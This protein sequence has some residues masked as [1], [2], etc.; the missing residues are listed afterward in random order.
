MDNKSLYT[1]NHT[2]KLIGDNK[3]ICFVITN[4]VHYSRCKQLLHTLKNH[5]T[6]DL[7]IVVAASALL[8]KYGEVTKELEKDGFVIHATINML[9]EGGSPIAMAKTTG[10]GLLEMSTVLE[11]LKPDIVVVRGDR[12]EVLSIAIAAAYLNIP[13]AHIEGG[14][15]T[16]TIDE[17]V[18]HAITKLAHL[19]FATNQLSKE[20][21][22]KMG[23]KQ[24]N[25]YD[26]GSLDVEYLTKL[27][28]SF[29]HNLWEVG[30][31]GLGTNFDLNQGYV[32]V[33]QHP[34][35]TEYGSGRQ[36]M[37]ET[38]KAI[39]E[40][41]VPTIWLWPN[42][43][44][45]NDEITKALRVYRE[46]QKPDFIHFYRFLA[47]EM[48]AKV[49]AH[50]KCLVGNS[51]A[52]IKECSYLGTPVV[53][54]GTRQ[55]GRLR[56]ENVVDVPYNAAVIK[57]AIQT[58]LQKGKYPKSPVYLKEQTSQKIADI[59]SQAKVDIQKKLTY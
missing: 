20:R 25:V 59:L 29:P 15:V 47:P 32:V 11:N 27:D 3:K 48:F 38:I 17:S 55:S 36:Q 43:D 5:P 42:I 24:E 16:G 39:H 26:V 7:Q 50:A 40:L 28:L 45:G 46:H 1:P 14:D 52:G 56:A 30:P 53:N 31:Q 54:I 34:V 21:I 57:N 33:L 2:S 51:S 6:I 10:L 49:I 37:E 58:Q 18:R 4:R 13:L 9:L 12:Y 44:A 22:I 23:E 8:P 41:K 35:T 19:H